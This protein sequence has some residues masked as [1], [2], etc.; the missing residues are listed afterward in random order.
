M[1]CDG[2]APYYEMLERVSFGNWLR[3]TRTTYLAEVCGAQRALLCGGGDGRFLV[4]LLEADR[5]VRVDYVDLSAEM[6]RIA[7]RR[8][9]VMGHEFSDRVRFLVGDVRDVAATAGNYDLIAT[10][11]FL[12]CFNERELEEIVGLLRGCAA[13]GAQW[14]VSEFHE[15]KTRVGRVWS[16]A[17]IS[18]MYTAFGVVT[19]LR[20]ARLPDYEAAL[21]EGGFRMQN[22]RK[23]LGGLLR[24]SLWQT[25]GL[26]V[27]R[28]VGGAEN[29]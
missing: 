10:H 2:I 16:R 20:V 4:R 5:S 22:A 29:V 27:R 1:N 7:R 14:L 11:F 9:V 21:V 18:G 26:G 12:D 25:A 8:V 6:A 19:G 15:V 24:A 13:P 28:V 17:L 23:L 3:R